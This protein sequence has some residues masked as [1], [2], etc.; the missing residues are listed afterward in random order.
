MA[1]IRSFRDLEVYIQA[2]QQAK[3]VFL[4]SKRFPRDE[5]YSMTDQIRRSSRAVNAMI[6]EAWA[7]RMYR[8]SFVNKIDE[9]LGE[10]METQAWLDH[11]FD[12]GYLNGE[13]HKGLDDIWQRI[14]A[15]L[16][17][18]I[19]RADDFCRTADRL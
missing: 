1:A 14:G 15:M 16:N 9:A 12:C 13:E 2:R 4:V 3:N 8:A 10:A 7:R 11:A 18:M 6:A 17:R 19:Q 5:R